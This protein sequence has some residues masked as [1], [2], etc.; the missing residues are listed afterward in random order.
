MNWI[1]LLGPAIVAAGV[2]GAI[3]V[4]GFIFTTRRLRIDRLEFDC[5]LTAHK[6]DLDNALAEIRAAADRDHHDLRELKRAT[7]L[8]EQA[9]AEF[10]QVK[11]IINAGRSLNGFGARWPTETEGYPE[12][13]VFGRIDHI[14]AEIK[15]FCRPGGTGH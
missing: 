9:V 2:S 12:L 3:V 4:V 15:Q 6:V 13:P 14:I 7:Q 1:S 8:A 10:Y 11:H 5:A